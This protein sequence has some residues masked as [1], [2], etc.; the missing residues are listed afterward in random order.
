MQIATNMEIDILDKFSTNLKEVLSKSLEA[1][2]LNNRKKV[3]PIILLRALAKQRGSIAYEILHRVNF[4]PAAEEKNVSSSSAG[5]T[6]TKVKNITPVLSPESKRAIEKA[7]LAANLFS[8][9]YVGTEHLLFGLLEINNQDMAAELHAQGINIENLKNLVKNILK[10]TSKFPDIVARSEMMRQAD[11]GE[12]ES[13]I[14]EEN[15]D[16]SYM[17]RTQIKSK[18]ATL[19]FFSVDLT[20]PEIQNNVDPLIGR[21][22]EV[23]RL[24]Q[25]LCRRHKN[26]PLL[27]GDPGVGKTAIV[28]GLAKQIMLGQVPAELSDKKILALD[29]SLIIA[30]TMYRGEF[31]ARLKQIIEEIK[32][33]KNLIIFI[34]EV[35]NLVG[36]G[37]TAGSLDAANILKPALARGELHCIGATT[38]EEYKKHIESDP[39]LERRFQTIVTK[40]PSRQEALDILNGI[41][42]NYEK[43]HNVKIHDQAIIAAVDLSTRFLTD[44]FLPDKAIDLIDEAASGLKLS[45]PI[46]PRTSRLRK[47]K[48]ELAQTETI[49]RQAVLRE[50]YPEAVKL[51]EKEKEL[52]QKI[53]QAKKEIN[54]NQIACRE[55]GEN[56][57]F[58][59]I[60]KQ[61][62]VDAREIRH[63]LDKNFNDLKQTLGRH[64]VGQD[65]VIEELVK[66][67]GRTKIGLNNPSRPLASFL[68]VGP[69]G[70]GKTE[71][72][73]TLAQ[74]LYP[75]QDAL[76]Q[77][78]MAEFRESFTASK[79]LGSPAG[80]VGYNDRNK[81]TDEVRRKPYAVILFDEF[82]KA[83]A[84]IQNLLLQL[85]DQGV[86]SD[87][88]GRKIN[89]KSTIIVLTTNLGQELFSQ[90]IGFEAAGSRTLADISAVKKELGAKISDHFK[91]EL[92]NRLDSLLYFKPIDRT[93]L[94]KIVAWELDRICAYAQ[95]FGIEL[96][97]DPNIIVNI[98]SKDYQP[99]YGARSIKKAIL[100]LIENPLSEMILNGKINK[101]DKIGAGLK[102]GKVEFGKI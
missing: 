58:E 76:I 23:Q 6:A 92:L 81:F 22:P 61:L 48:N 51:K 86:I 77:I 7:V 12:I 63:G 88:A 50:R 1:V 34:D 33:D 42:T 60:A 83:H 11:A 85:L 49:K 29:L 73:K 87:G 36:A 66:V 72:A 90:K 45:G 80:Y 4:R 67:V 20:S 70:V 16:M 99:E 47:L 53:F 57:I 74:T 18:N 52:Q 89:F 28:E 8:H 62:G 65:H 46:D 2:I 82:E 37:A 38:L 93:A 15:L 3:E 55:L 5:A 17:D 32:S 31:E 21:E 68:F 9:K 10:T 100:S 97:L 41:K 101:G 44:K 96:N 27:L 19:E 24:M 54:Q 40:E 79:L 56:H 59:I 35:H 69:S 94:Q 71:L 102:R 30:G 91:P 78:D 25:V 39:A 98:V 75:N 43:F 64:I 14:L 13:T 95:N 84:D 26:N